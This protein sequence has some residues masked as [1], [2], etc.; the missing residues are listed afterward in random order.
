MTLA[1]A[2]PTHSQLG[3]CSP[4]MIAQEIAPGLF[5]STPSFGLEPEGHGECEE[6][7]D[8]LVI[9]VPFVV[10]PDFIDIRLNY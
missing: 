7:M 4:E 6:S 3:G 5:V 1:S 8:F 2:A 10:Q 9:F